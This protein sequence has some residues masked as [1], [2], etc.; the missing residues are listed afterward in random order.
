M[1]VLEGKVAFISGGARGQGRS[2][3]IKMA[4]EGADIIT[5]DICESFDTVASPG[6]TEE[7]L[8]QTVKEVEALGRRIVA[9]KADVRDQAGVQAIFDRGVDELGR[10]DIVLANA[11]IMPIVGEPSRVRQAWHDSIDV[12]LTG[13][14][15][16]CEAAIPTLLAQGDG[17][18]IVITSST[19]G[20]KGP[21]RTL[22]VKSDG[23]LGYIA[24]KHGVVGL[25]RSYANALGPYKIRCNTVHPTGVSSPMTANEQVFAFM[26]EHP[27]I[28]ESMHNILPTDLIEPE[29]ISNMMVF[30]CSDAGRYITG[31]TV[32]VDAGATV[33]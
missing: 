10:C 25:M 6:A 4:T 9:E 19:A 23:T 17:G 11:G 16:T 30:L 1:G 28:G 18:C 31:A 20:T 8:A 21:M 7:D 15:H 26:T 29:D 12:M 27:E 33:Y 13:V 32:H 24:A 3:A 5:F 14:F 22:D 2:H